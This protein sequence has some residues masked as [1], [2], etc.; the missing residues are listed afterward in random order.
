MRCDV[1]MY[2]PHYNGF[3]GESHLSEDLL[4][5]VGHAYQLL[6]EPVRKVPAQHVRDQQGL[7]ERTPTQ[8]DIYL[9]IIY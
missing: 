5:L 9:F 3:N 6:D 4:L 7:V 8:D 2:K 1:G